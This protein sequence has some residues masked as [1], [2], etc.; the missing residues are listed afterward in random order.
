MQSRDP[1]EL[2]FEGLETQKW[3]VPTDWAQ[4][5]DEK[6]G[7]ICLVIMFPSRNMVAEM[8][9]FCIFCWWQQKLVAVWEKDLIE[10]SYWVLSEN[11]MVK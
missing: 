1:M 9:F 10:E 7:V 3:N 8:S 4:K 2:N 11:G 6:T 5:V